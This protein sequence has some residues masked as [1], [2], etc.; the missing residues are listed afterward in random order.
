M[1]PQTQALSAGQ[2]AS[3]EGGNRPETG[4]LISVDSPLLR[5]VRVGLDA[6]LGLATL[7]VQELLALKAGSVVKLEARMNDLIE[8]RLNDSVVARGEIVAVDD[9]F[10]IRIVEVAEIA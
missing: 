10:G 9:N 7:S 3:K 4:P 6:K 8:L 5:E 1:K 2:G